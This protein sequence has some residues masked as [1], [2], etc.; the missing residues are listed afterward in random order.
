MSTVLIIIL[1]IAVVGLF[2]VY[3]LPQIWKPKV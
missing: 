2:C 3:V 1:I